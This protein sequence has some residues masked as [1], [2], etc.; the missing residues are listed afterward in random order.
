MP[1]SPAPVT[2]LEQFLAREPGTIMIHLHWVDLCGILRARVLTKSRCQKVAAS[3]QPARGL[4]RPY[5]GH[6]DCND[7]PESYLPATRSLLCPDW[8]SL[9]WIREGHASVMCDVREDNES[10]GDCDPGDTF[11]RCS[12]YALGRI[13]RALYAEHQLTVIIGIEIEFFLVDKPSPG[14]WPRIDTVQAYN[15]ASQASSVRDK[16][17]IVLV[18]CIQHLE[19]CGISVEQYHAEGG[20]QQLEISLSALEAIAAADAYVRSKEIISNAASLHGQ[21]AT[22]LPQPFEGAPTSG[23]HVHA[24]FT[25]GSPDSQHANIPH[26]IAGVLGRLPLL[27]AF[28][29]PSEDSYK[30]VSSLVTGTWVSWGTENRDNPVRRI[31]DN[32]WEFRAIDCMANIYVVL[33]AY[34]GAGLLGLQ[35]DEHLRWGDNRHFQHRLDDAQ[36]TQLGIGPEQLPT[37]LQEAATLLRSDMRGLDAVMGPKLVDLFVVVQEA[38][39]VLA[40]RMSADTRAALAFDAY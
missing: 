6:T 16:A 5:L 27:C 19:R 29:M 33:S 37:S 35:E 21:L 2:V 14:D 38:Q 39:Q 3:G 4:P 23:L 17:E 22:F 26:F 10:Y 30:R 11:D 31:E 28:A 20:S 7:M 40:S 24:S 15:H 36:R 1:P 12:R 13:V 8:T 34:L 18:A 25:K 32:H 9:R